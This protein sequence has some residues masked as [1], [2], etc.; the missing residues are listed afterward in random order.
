MNDRIGGGNAFMQVSV[1]RAVITFK[2]GF[3]RLVRA[4]TDYG[5]VVVLDPRLL[6]A[7]YGK[8]FINSLPRMVKTQD[9]SQIRAF[10]DD[11]AAGVNQ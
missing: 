8:R 10:L 6:S 9:L 11:H 4:V 7:G 2:Q 3:G 1:P 5:V